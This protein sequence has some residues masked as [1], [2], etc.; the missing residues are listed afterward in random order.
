MASMLFCS[1]WTK[2]KG[3]APKD[4]KAPASGGSRIF[5]TAFPHGKGLQEHLKRTYHI[6]KVGCF[7]PKKVENWFDTR[8]DQSSLFVCVFFFGSHSL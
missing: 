6:T 7:V 4:G 5:F 3:F 8:L 2:V 1:A